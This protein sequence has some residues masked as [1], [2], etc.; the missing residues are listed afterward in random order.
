M[1]RFFVEPEEMQSESIA[2]TG[3]NAK[4]AKVLRLKDGE[5]VLVATDTTVFSGLVRSNGTAAEIVNCLKKE[6]R[7][8]QIVE[9]LLAEYDVE[10]ERVET[11]V[12]K[13]LDTLRSIGALDE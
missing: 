11:D 5:Q 7:K 8:E 2:L 13:I 6:T 9:H 4:H 1:T 12:E 3:E 10:R